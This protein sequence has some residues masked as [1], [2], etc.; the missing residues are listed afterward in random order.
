M[1]STERDEGMRVEAD[2]DG[3]EEF[4]QNGKEVED[5]NGK[6]EIRTKEEMSDLCEQVNG[7]K[8]KEEEDDGVEKVEKEEK[9]EV[10]APVETF[11][12]LSDRGKPW[13]ATIYNTGSHLSFLFFMLTHCQPDGSKI[14]T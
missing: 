7:D 5:R 1:N 10:V 2:K 12:R 13:I 3:V 4:D 9:V 14:V 6:K 8:V 11:P